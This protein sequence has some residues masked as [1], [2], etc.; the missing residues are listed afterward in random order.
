MNLFFRRARLGFRG[1]PYSNLNYTLSFFY[2]NV[3]HDSLAATRNQNN[4]A[5]KNGQASDVTSAGTVVGVWDAF[6]TWKLS[7]ESDLYHVTAGYLRPQIS[8]ESLTPAFNVNSF[9]KA[10]SQNYVRQAV[11]GRG[12]G[13]AVGVNFGGLYKGQGWGTRYNFGLF[14]R[15][16][17]GDTVTGTTTV[18]E[19]QGSSSSPVLVARSEFYLGAPEMEKYSLSLP[20][21]FF[22]KR[23]GVTVAVNASHQERTPTYAG[24]RTLGADVLVNYGYWTFD[25]EAFLIS[26]QAKNAS[27]FATSKTGHARIG[28]SIPLANQTHLEPAFM[29]SGFFGDDG[30]E[31]RG[32]DVQLD[33]GV[34]WYL[35]ENKYKFYLHYVHQE[36]SGSNL[37]YR[38]DRGYD[39]GDY[40]GL[41]L[42]L[43]F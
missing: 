31:F 40:A 6:L 34:N 39:Y 10:I 43:Q 27:N 24:S 14:N 9:E 1:T 11:I 23:R 17:T 41:G 22:G 30:A 21:N 5:T 8:R 13:R 26:Y 16:T 36:A 37:G 18:G 32:R 7:S 12:F 25:A 15:M 2:D 35:D 20:H 19:T 28:Y 3:G 33:A 42:T 38:A 29:A 4:P